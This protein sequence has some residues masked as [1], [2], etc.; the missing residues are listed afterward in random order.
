MSVRKGHQ[1]S[2]TTNIGENF[3]NDFAA[4]YENR[5]NEAMSKV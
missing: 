3:S 1:R 2:I 4:S 5:H